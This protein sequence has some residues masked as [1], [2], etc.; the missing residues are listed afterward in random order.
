[1]LPEYRELEVEAS[2]LNA[3][4]NVLVDENTLDAQLL[5]AMEAALRDEAPPTRDSVALIRS[6]RRPAWFYQTQSAR[7]LMKCMFSIGP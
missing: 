5:D 3:K 2:Q 1:M 4:I 6:I 7:G